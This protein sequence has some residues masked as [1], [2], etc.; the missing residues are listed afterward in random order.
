V[1]LINRKHTIFITIIIVVWSAGVAFAGDIYK[2][3]DE[4]GNIHYGDRPTSQVI[5]EPI[6]GS[7]RDIDS[8]KDRARDEAK[9]D[10]NETAGPTPK[11]LSAQAIEREE[12]CASYKARLRKL[13]SSRRLY[14]N[15]EY[16]ERVYL[17]E[18]EIFAAREIVQ[19]QVEEYCNK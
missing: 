5:E 17:D 3:T 2:W 15:D 12:K 10:A 18:D 4:H 9:E 1:N 13:L 8:S 14:K 11:E 7:S 16:G 19:N 6:G